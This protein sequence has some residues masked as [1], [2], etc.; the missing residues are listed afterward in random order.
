MESR[1][2]HDFSAVRIHDSEVA[3]RSAEAIGARAYTVGSQIVFGR[4]GYAPGSTAG[5]RT[6][7]HELVH[8]LQQRSG[9]VDGVPTA[10]GQRIS[11]PADRFER[12]AEAIARRVTGDGS[13]R[14]GAGAAPGPGGAAHRPLAGS[15][16]MQR[17]GDDADCGCEH[18]EALPQN[19]PGTAV[20]ATIQRACLSGAACSSAHGSATGFGAESESREAAARRRRAGMSPARQRLH[21]HTGHARALETFFNSQVPGLVSNF[22]GFFVDQDLD[23]DTGALQ[24]DCAQMVPP[25]TGATKPCIFVHGDL[26]QQA[27]KFNT[28]P[29]ATTIGGRSRETWRIDTVQLIVHENQHLL[30]GGAISGTA[31]PAGVTSCTRAAVDSDLSELNA[32]MSEFVIAFRAIPA[33]A[34][35]TDPASLRLARWFDFKIDTA[36]EN[37]R[38]NLRRLRCNCDCAD[39]DRFIK[40]TFNFATSS[41]S[42]AEKDAFNAELRRPARGLNWPL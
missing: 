17:C 33:G 36:G 31:V 28:D 7:A 32:I 42:V 11:D 39:A 20:P 9:P 16:V 26:N 18:D 13:P 34:P 25:I 14:A 4:D 27:L 10:G 24:E 2:G 3:H 12:A 37:I 1:L 30:Y 38:D 23:P 35:A 22:H 21:G 5:R 40:E 19:G 6:L 29:T 15:V 41:W 8:V